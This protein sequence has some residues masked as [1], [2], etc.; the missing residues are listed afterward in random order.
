[1]AT[2]KFRLK[3]RPIIDLGRDVNNSH[4]VHLR[5][6]V[7][8]PTVSKYLSDDPATLDEMRSLDLEVLYG[9][10]VDGLGLSE[11]EVLNLRLG[12]ILEVQK[13]GR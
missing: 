1:M 5:S 13:G 9:I 7:S 10:L 2:G 6:Q 4:Q 11:E 12:E 3:G 8:W